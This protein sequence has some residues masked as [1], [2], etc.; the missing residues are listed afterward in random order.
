MYKI[1]DDVAD[2]TAFADKISLSSQILSK[3]SVA[4]DNESDESEVPQEI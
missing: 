4:S 1:P 2:L 3:H